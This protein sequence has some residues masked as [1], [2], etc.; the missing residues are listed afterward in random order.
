MAIKKF[1]LFKIKYLFCI[2]VVLL[3]GC[4]DANHGYGWDYLYKYEGMRVRGESQLT[5]GEIYAEY[6]KA[7]MCFGDKPPPF[8]IFA[9]QIEYDDIAA[10]RCG[11]AFSNPPLIV[12]KVPYQKEGT[13]NMS[14]NNQSHAIAHEMVHYFVAYSHKKEFKQGL[15]CIK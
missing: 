5:P 1:T 15:Q 8:I 7:V 9:N 3:I 6:E 12:I 13:V 14:C 11:R 4:G 10:G 2:S